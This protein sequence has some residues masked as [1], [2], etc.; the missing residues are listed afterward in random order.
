MIKYIR[1][2]QLFN[3][4]SVQSTKLQSGLRIRVEFERIRSS[5][6]KVY[7]D[8]ILRKQSSIITDSKHLDSVVQIRFGSKFTE[9]S[10]PNSYASCFT[11]LFTLI[12]VSNITQSNS[13]IYFSLSYSWTIAKEM[14]VNKPMDPFRYILQ[15]F[16][17]CI[18]ISPFW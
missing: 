6:K 9:K 12:S 7:P 17:F 11:L 10:D 8:P 2:I 15:I 13:S 5:R 18:W 4:L 3:S 1:H 14:F 16:F